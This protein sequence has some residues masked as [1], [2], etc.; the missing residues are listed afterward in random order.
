MYIF[1]YIYIC[2]FTIIYTHIK[3]FFYRLDFVFLCFFYL[4]YLFWNSLYFLY[5][6]RT[7]CTQT[8]YTPGAYVSKKSRITPYFYVI[9][10]LMFWRIL[11][12][13][14]N[15]SVQGV[16]SGSPNSYTRKPYALLESWLGDI[17]VSLL[18]CHP[19]RIHVH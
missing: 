5:Q 17:Y 10:T 19:S 9:N 8:W 2:V 7:C 6:L 4:L 13:V 15:T 3:I 18:T 14:E 12:S 16:T 11:L 1:I